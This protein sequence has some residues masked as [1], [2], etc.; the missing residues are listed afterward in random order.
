MESTPRRPARAHAAAIAMRYAA[1]IDAL[2]S[3]RSGRFSPGHE[4]V[5]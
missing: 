5:R 4:P 1:G 2:Y 3:S